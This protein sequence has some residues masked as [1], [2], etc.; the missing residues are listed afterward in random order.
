[1]RLDA[2]RSSVRVKRTDDR[3]RWVRSGALDLGKAGERWS[4][5]FWFL[6][7]VACVL[8]AALVWY[9]W[10][11]HRQQQLYYNGMELSR[12]YFHF[13]RDHEG[14]LPTSFDDLTSGSYLTVVEKGAVYLGPRPAAPEQIPVFYGKQLFYLG[15]FELTYGG[16]VRQFEVRG[17]RVYRRGTDEEVIFVRPPS[18]SLLLS[19]R[20]NSV[21]IVNHATGNGDP[22]P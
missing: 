18:Q 15:K 13:V 19:A 22:K 12:A 11:I 10:H 8:V 6:G 16:H 2:G 5:S 4:V 14:A 7:A 21:A 20:R 3:R 1:M 17:E 9:G